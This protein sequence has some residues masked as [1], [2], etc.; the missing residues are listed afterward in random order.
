MIFQSFIALLGITFSISYQSFAY[1]VQASRWIHSESKQVFKVISDRHSSD[2]SVEPAFLKYCIELRKAKG[3]GVFLV[4]GTPQNYRNS[5]ELTRFKE[6]GQQLRIPLPIYSII[7]FADKLRSSFG[8]DHQLNRL[9]DHRNLTLSTLEIISSQRQMNRSFVFAKAQLAKQPAID[10]KS[11]I[12]VSTIFSE[13]KSIQDK[14]REANKRLKNHQAAGFILEDINQIEDNFE[15]IKENTAPHQLNLDVAKYLD[16]IRG[17]SEL[18]NRLQV[19]CIEIADPMMLIEAATAIEAGIEETIFLGGYHH[20]DK[21]SE[22]IGFVNFQLEE[23]IQTEDRSSL[24]LEAVAG[25][26]QAC[27]KCDQCNDY[28]AQVKCCAGCKLAKYCSQDCQKKAWLSH[29]APCKEIQAKK[30]DDSL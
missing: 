27:D 18:I 1:P 11:E 5:A 16:E 12:K 9:F 25:V 4:E 20:A 8:S 14:A 10:F 28:F 17:N 23:K 22:F 3:H 21:V 30:K 19:L 15:V 26:L 6:L 24:R 29:K 2:S 13:V 7:E